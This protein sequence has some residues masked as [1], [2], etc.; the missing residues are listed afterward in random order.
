V[1]LARWQPIRQKG[2]KPT[3]P[4]PHVEHPERHLCGLSANLLDAR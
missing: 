4:A 2:A 1:D 3:I